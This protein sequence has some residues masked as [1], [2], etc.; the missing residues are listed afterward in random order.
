MEIS[1]VQ[2]EMIADAHNM[3]PVLLDRARSAEENRAVTRDT[4][5]EF[6]EKGFFR[7]HQPER[8]GGNAWDISMMDSFFFP[9]KGREGRT[10]G[11]WP[12]C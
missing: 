7:I 3:I 1:N 12:Y 10:C 2:T 4:F 11:R 8:F 6:T 9:R 5:D